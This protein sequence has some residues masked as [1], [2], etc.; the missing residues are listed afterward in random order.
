MRKP[1]LNEVL[2]EILREDPRY[3]ADAYYFLR[4]ALDH[5]IKA[6]SKPAQGL[7]R[8][9][10]GQELLEGIRQYALLEYGPL[11]KRVFGY[12]G[13][14]RCEDFGAMVFHLVAKGVLGKT[15]QD[16]LEDFQGGYDFEEA[17]LQPYRPKP[18]KKKPAR[19]ST[20][21]TS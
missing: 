14:Q 2:E 6:F 11:A 1:S 7:A 12:W 15:D 20:R 9:V 10:S 4:E 5:T 21:P 19:Q 13:V 3:A 8:H 16:R 17:F 18:T